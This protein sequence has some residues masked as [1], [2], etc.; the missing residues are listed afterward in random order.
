MS[1]LLMVIIAKK[2]RID[3]PIYAI[4]SLPIPLPLPLNRF[5]HY[6]H[7]NTFYEELSKTAWSV[8]DA[9]P[10]HEEEDVS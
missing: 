1:Y 8:L 9:P 3:T 6:S 7:Y 2:K 4:K 10:P 5:V